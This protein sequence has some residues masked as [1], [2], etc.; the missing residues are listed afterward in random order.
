MLFRSDLKANRH[1]GFETLTRLRNRRSL[2]PE[3][4]F[5]PSTL[6][7]LETK[8]S[9][10]ALQAAARLCATLRGKGR[11]ISVSANCSSSVIQTSEYVA[12][13]M[14][15][16]REWNLPAGSLTIEVTEDPRPVD[17]G[18]LTGA[19]EMLR[20][21]GIGFALDDFGKH[22]ANLDR[23]EMLPVN[24]V[25]VDKNLFSACFDQRVPPSLLK[26]LIAFCRD[27]HLFTVI[28]G[29]ETTEQLDFAQQ[30]G[31]DFGQGFYWGR[32]M[33]GGALG[34]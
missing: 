7:P 34:I 12:S 4:I 3:L 33:S 6:L 26:E 9:I 27:R 18:K 20:G 17:T 28:E 13:A 25:K 32:P 22:S 5:A 29:I 31:A 15:L 23:I 24:E 19:M 10:M 14:A 21:S 1:C 11:Q 2:S 16:M 30:L 8:A